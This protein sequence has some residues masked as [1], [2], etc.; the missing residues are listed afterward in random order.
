MSVGAL[1]GWS[2]SFGAHI[3][4]AVVALLLGLVPQVH[5]GPPLIVP[6]FEVQAPGLQ[7]A[8][9]VCVYFIAYRSQGPPAV[10]LVVRAT[11]SRSAWCIQYAYC[12]GDPVNK[13]DPSGL[14]WITTDGNNV[15]Y[16]LTDWDQNPVGDPIN[17]GTTDGT[18]INMKK[19]YGGGLLEYNS[20]R[21]FLDGNRDGSWQG[22]RSFGSGNV[23]D[24]GAWHIGRNAMKAR[25]YGDAYSATPV[26]EF[27]YGAAKVGYEPIGLVYSGS[28]GL[29]SGGN[30]TS[31]DL[32]DADS[33]LFG[34]TASRLDAGDSGAMAGLKTGAQVLYRGNPFTGIPAAGYDIYEGVSTSNWEQVG[35]GTAGLGLQLA[36]AASAIKAG[37][38][39]ST[40]TFAAWGN[41]ISTIGVRG[42]VAQQSSFPTFGGW[43]VYANA[44][45]NG[46]TIQGARLAA[47]E[48]VGALHE[49]NIVTGMSGL[50]DEV[51]TQLTVRPRTNAG[52]IT[53]YG[54]RLD[55]VGLNNGVPALLLEGKASLTAPLTGNQ[56]SGFPLIQRNGAVVR[57][58][59]GGTSLPAG[60][61]IAPQA[62]VVLRW[63]N[64]GWVPVVV[65]G[66]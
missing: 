39:L 12:G 59:R 5:A 37:A 60:T 62:V 22:V 56:A 48:Y 40:P 20:F 41:T 32:G 4:V 57:G 53:G 61:Q 7:P 33:M 2:R 24:W 11:S 38:P 23:G 64:G 46:S 49:Q 31:A 63:V 17:I 8:P 35:G 65:T 15:M 45:L 9:V 42:F 55:A 58:A 16:Q 34:Y 3:I 10:L 47:N 6:A 29:L 50:F 66:N 25:N 26:A 43:S 13:W 1:S 44:R 36:G 52:G 18:W 14:D 21:L 27:L 54:T 30:L 51:L 19:E 28:R